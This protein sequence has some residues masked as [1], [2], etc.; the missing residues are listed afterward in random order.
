MTT[1]ARQ[2]ISTF[3]WEYQL[4]RLAEE[5]Q[6]A[7]AAGLRLLGS[8]TDNWHRHDGNEADFIIEIAD[9]SI[10]LD[11]F[12]TRHKLETKE[13][14]EIHD[15]KHWIREFCTQ[16]SFT[17]S[18]VQLYVEELQKNQSGPSCI[19]GLAIGRAADV[20][21]LLNEAGRFIS[22]EAISR[23]KETKQ[24]RL[25]EIIEAQKVKTSNHSAGV[26]STVA[27]KPEDSSG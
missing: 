1:L 22:E 18:F 26:C 16:C 11:Q 5:C 12:E 9:V 20:K 21:S 3:G 6:E 8:Q 2:A 25:R 23:A 14:P 15:K 10:M 4:D 13:I 17:A 7:S 24:N 19:T 27:E